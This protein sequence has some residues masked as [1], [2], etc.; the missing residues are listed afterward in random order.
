MPEETVLKNVMMD[1]VQQETVART[2]LARLLIQGEAVHKRVEVLSGGEKIKVAFA[3]LFVSN[4][5]VLLLDEPTNY[6]DMQSIEALEAV[7]REYEGTVLFVSHDRSFVNGVADRLLILQDCRIEAFNG[8]LEEYEEYKQYEARRGSAGSV[9][10]SAAKNTLKTAVQNEQK[11]AVKST[12]D[13]AVPGCAPE[14]IP[15]GIERTL[16]QM[17]LTEIIA[18]LS[19]ANDGSEALE[20]E[21]T[22]LVEL[23]RR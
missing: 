23:L 9:A 20:E 13:G 22:R 4:A 1:S 7:L 8:K 19:S 14:S 11:T 6:L 10:K 3:K 21:Y 16:L 5:N 15:D 12:I 17:R 18:K 2:I